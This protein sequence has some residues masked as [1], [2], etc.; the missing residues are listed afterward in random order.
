M[1]TE[2]T[3]ND[4]EVLGKVKIIVD[5]YQDECKTI[6][7]KNLLYT[8]DQLSC[9]TYYMSDI[10]AKFK[11]NYND[12]YFIRKIGVSKE[13]TNLIKAGSKIGA[14]T[15]EANLTEDNIKNF[16]K[17]LDNE[18]LALKTECLLKAMYAIINAIAGR[19][20]HLE[21]E[22]QISNRQQNIKNS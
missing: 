3:K 4:L 10:V 5:W 11:K 20:R 14:A 6:S 9:Y 21:N 12:A 22:K 16:Q 8:R 17:E 19:I 1:S 2:F 7:I 13:K 18:Y 15:D